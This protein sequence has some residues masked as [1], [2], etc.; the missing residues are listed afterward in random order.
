MDCRRE[1]GF[2]ERLAR[3]LA[4]VA[5]LAACWG[6]ALAQPEVP[7]PVT[8]AL[9]ARSL[10]PEDRKDIRV[11]HGVWTEEDLDTPARKARAALL[12]GRWDDPALADPQAD[13]LDRA[14][15]LLHRGE[16]AS[17]LAI[18]EPAAKEI[19]LRR[20]RLR[21]VALVWGGREAEAEGVLK[22]V[23]ERL[24]TVE[25]ASADEL[26]EGVRALMVR[27]N[28]SPSVTGGTRADD[29][30]AM[31]SMLARAR[32]DLDRLCWSASLAEAELLLAKDNGAQ[33]NEAAEDALNLNPRSAVGMFVLGSIA[34]DTFGID[35]AQAIAERL[36]AEVPHS[37]H[38]AAIMARAR[39][40]QSDPA[41]AIEELTPALAVFP[42]APMLLSLEA[43]AAA[44]SFDFARTDGLL[45]AFDQ[46]FPG[47]GAAYFEVGRALSDARQYAEAAK[48][49]GEAARRAPGWPDPIIEL[50]LLE[51]QAGR[52]AEA[53]QALE[54]A[55]AL[56]PFNVRV[57][58][59]LT[60]V[61]ELLSYSKVES[62]HFVVRFKPGVDEI[63]AREMLGPLEGIFRRVT[64]SEKGGI[65]HAPAGK[66]LIE[67]MPDHRWFAVRIAGMPR[68]HT[69][70]AAT[71]P[72]I[73]MEAPRSGPNHLVGPYDWERVVRHEYVHTVT[74]SRTNNRLPHWFTEAAAVYLEDAPRD[75]SAWSIL[76]R[77]F[78][79]DTLF[80]FDKINL[81][82]IRPEKPTDRQQAYAQ[83][84]WMYEYIVES[85]GA[86]APLELMDL[87]AQG[88]KE[89]EA[90]ERVLKI[91]RDEFMTRFKAWGKVQLEQAG[92]LPA[93]G[94]PSMVD[95]LG[96]R[97]EKGPTLEEIDEALAKHPAHP[98]LLR[99]AIAMRL[100]RSKNE[101]T[102]ELVPLLERYARARP[103][104]PL[105]HKL[106]A[107]W[108]MSGGGQDR[109]EARARAI[110]HLT[111]LDVREQYS[112]AYASEL[113][114]RHA[115]AGDWDRSWASALRAVRIAPYDARTRELAATVAI[116][117]NDF[118]E[119]RHHLRALTQ[120]EP[121]RTIHTKR[122]ERLD[123][124][125]KRSK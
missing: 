1:R 63:L 76:A 27:A 37:A 112:P 86:R 96:D 33:A 45:K 75:Y 48:Y 7:E 74:L 5:G 23:A 36:R 28:L 3:A 53:L 125:E 78:V 35:E 109:P 69:I 4:L 82:F 16:W 84:H 18:L 102:E 20:E 13:V 94:T 59:S 105:P 12:V 40:R 124:L 62:D 103:V 49:L 66:T 21:A 43:A 85:A 67:L 31:M 14:E 38:A 44:L 57:G 106:L 92:M 54:R 19:S 90:F 42:A 58:N 77:A 52:D 11:R 2:G 110:E 115:A 99:Q 117:R 24:G 111:Y 32:D 6:R 91:T 15:A 64:G 93:P 107:T 30:R 47:S 104:D 80:D 101:P 29:F 10:T 116:K 72:V 71:G 114:E 121:D 119:A 39:L 118:A 9:S 68:I 60:L 122:L 123:E 61:R 55:A 108:F 120:I 34:V 73:A 25:I 98:D 50:G 88:V 89:A 87:Y 46:R 97:G 41:G 8:R 100:E 65:D 79:D 95:V 26:V 83:G 17:A 51:V 70:A 56:D 81:A 22:P 113:A